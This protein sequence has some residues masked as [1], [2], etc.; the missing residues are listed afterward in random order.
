[1]RWNWL[2]NV[3]RRGGKNDC[4]T[5]LDWRPEGRRVKGR[6]RTTWKR[7]VEKDHNKAGWTSWS[8]ARMAGKNSA[9]WKDNVTALCALWHEE[10]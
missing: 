2:S 5:A 4:V 8:I 9:G 10:K 1:M 7:T 6:P 3:L